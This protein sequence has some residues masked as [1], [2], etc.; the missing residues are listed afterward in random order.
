MPSRRE[1]IRMNDQEVAEFLGGRRVL[2]VAS[3]GPDGNIHLVAMWYGFLRADNVADPAA[4]FD[5]DSL[6]IE[7]FGKSQKVLNYRRD[8]RFTGLVEAGDEYSELQGVELVGTAEVIDD[9]ATVV[10]SCKAVLARY[11]T[12]AE[13]SDLQFAAE[14]AARKRVCVR[15]HVE[16]VVSWDHTKLDVAY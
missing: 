14:L 2:N 8:P 4:R 10:E 1:M 15:F 3:H 7:T 6:V 13:P 16:K 12:F 11:Q 5:A 9:E